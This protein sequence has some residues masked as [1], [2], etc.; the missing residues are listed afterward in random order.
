MS[1]NLWKCPQNKRNSNLSSRTSKPSWTLRSQNSISRNQRNEE[2]YFHRNLARMAHFRGHTCVYRHRQSHSGSPAYTAPYRLY[3]RYDA[4][5]R[6]EHTLYYDTP[7]TN[8][9]EKGGLI[10]P[11]NSPMLISHISSCGIFA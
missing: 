8:G 11:P 1:K 10:R 2:F 4:N 7:K 5:N 6:M 9:K 3:F